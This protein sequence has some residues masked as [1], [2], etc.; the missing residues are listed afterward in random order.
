VQTTARRVRGE[1]N[2]PAAFAVERNPDP[3]QQARR[4][5]PRIL[6]MPPAI[7]AMER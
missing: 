2:Q 5:Y 7:D 4:S 6:S 3:P 1:A